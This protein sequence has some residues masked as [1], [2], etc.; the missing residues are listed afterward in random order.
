MQRIANAAG[1]TFPPKTLPP[2]ASMPLPSE[3]KGKHMERKRAFARSDS[4]K[5]EEAKRSG[6]WVHVTNEGENNHECSSE[7]HVPAYSRTLR[8]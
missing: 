8:F 6:A 7:V 1:T 3:R 4:L 2:P 5:V